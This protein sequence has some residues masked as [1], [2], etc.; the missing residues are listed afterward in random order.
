M[1]VTTR[2]PGF[3]RHD[4]PSDYWRFT[5]GDLA[6]AFDDCEIVSLEADTLDMG[7]YLIAMRGLAIDRPSFAVGLA[8]Q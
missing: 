7:S 2:A 1:I 4:F 5:R 6:R 3:P 8:P